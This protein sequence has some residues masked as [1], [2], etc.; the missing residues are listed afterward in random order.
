ME[1]CAIMNFICAI[2]NTSLLACLIVYVCFTVRYNCGI[3]FAYLLMYETNL[4][5][6]TFYAA[7]WC[8]ICTRGVTT[9]TG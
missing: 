3:F 4:I 5:I 2:V 6:F 9:H 7:V 8:T 1:R